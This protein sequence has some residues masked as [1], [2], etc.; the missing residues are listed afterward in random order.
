MTYP[1]STSPRS[2]V[3]RIFVAFM[4]AFSLSVLGS[5]TP[6]GPAA[7]A[8]DDDVPTPDEIENTADAGGLPSTDDDSPDA[9]VKPAK[10][11]KKLKPKP[12]RPQTKAATKCCLC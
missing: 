11:V 3:F 7:W 4:L 9:D 5:A 8:Q 2:R 10:K 1:A 6:W 12:K